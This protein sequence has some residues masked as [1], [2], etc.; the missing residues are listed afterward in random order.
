MKKIISVF[1]AILMVATIMPLSSGIMKAS[2]L[3]Q[4]NVLIW[5]PSDISETAY[6]EAGFANAVNLT[7]SK[8]IT[9]HQGGY[10][11]VLSCYETLLP[12]L[13]Y[14]IVSLYFL[15]KYDHVPSLP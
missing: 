8:K 6:E 12:F 1:L 5:S 7:K 9:S 10:F 14:P 4:P 3:E 2:A 15:Q 11:F 13:M